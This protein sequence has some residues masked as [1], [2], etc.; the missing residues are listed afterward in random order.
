MIQPVIKV[1]VPTIFASFSVAE[2]IAN[3]FLFAIF[4]DSIVSFGT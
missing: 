2:V 1:W 3:S 4:F